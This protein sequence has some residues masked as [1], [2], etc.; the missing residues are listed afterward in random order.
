MWNHFLRYFRSTG[1]FLMALSG[2]VF[3]KR[4][5][6]HTVCAPSRFCE[7]TSKL[8]RVA[9][10]GWRTPS[11][12]RRHALRGHFLSLCATFRASWARVERVALGFGG[13]VL[14]DQIIVFAHTIFDVYLVWE[15]HPS[16]QSG[17]K[18]SIVKCF[19]VWR[20][21]WLVALLS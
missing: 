6:M 15:V 19:S 4:A 3:W 18:L 21:Y 16:F 9:L 2:C 17:F 11:R 14:R 13:T 1:G 20:V 10:L 12:A 8:S 7:M 5:K